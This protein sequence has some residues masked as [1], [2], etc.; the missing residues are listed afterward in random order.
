[1][2]HPIKGERADAAVRQRDPSKSTSGGGACRKL[3]DSEKRLLNQYYR[4]KERC[5]INLQLGEWIID[6]QARLQRAEAFYTFTDY[7]QESPEELK[8]E[9]ERLRLAIRLAKQVREAKP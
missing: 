1:M 8:A 7:A 6:L 5:E 4:A 3:T 2:R 9:V